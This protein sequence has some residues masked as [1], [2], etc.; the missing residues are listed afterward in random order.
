M[1]NYGRDV[2]RDSERMLD[3]LP[4][5][6]LEEANELVSTLIH[7]SSGALVGRFGSTELR[8]IRRHFLRTEGSARDKILGLLTEGRLPFFSRF[9]NRKLAYDSGFYPL[10]KTHLTRFAHLMRD[11]MPSVDLLGS[12]VPGE[13]YFFESLKH[14]KVTELGNLSPFEAINPWSQALEGKRVLVIHPFAR[15]ISHQYGTARESLFPET[16]LLPFFE[17]DT[18]P[19]VQ[20]LGGPDPRFPTWFDALHWMRDEALTRDFDVAIVGCGAY[21]FPLSALLKQAGRTAIHLGGLVQ[22]L[23]GI[24]GARWDK[25]PAIRNLYNS[26]WVRPFS[27]EVPPNAARLGQGSYW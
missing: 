27:D 14:A 7:S 15:T 4:N 5:L 11:S 3:L 22:I 19:A 13:S 18:L 12:W 25:I 20:S 26:H 24:K 2:I 21:G 6:A 1:L 8:A 23:F 10:D 17:L 9:E 16:D